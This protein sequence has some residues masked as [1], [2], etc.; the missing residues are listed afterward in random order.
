MGVK[1]G[2]AYMPG[3]KVGIKLNSGNECGR[4]GPVGLFSRVQP[5]GPDYR[6]T[7]AGVRADIDQGTNRCAGN[8]MMIYYR[9]E[10][11]GCPAHGSVKGRSVHHDGLCAGKFQRLVKR[12]VLD[13][14][15]VHHDGKG[16]A[17]Y[18][19]G[20]RHVCGIPGAKQKFAQGI[21]RTIAS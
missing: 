11:A 9:N 4:R 18:F 5:V 6:R 17:P 7:G 12:E 20:E 3:K 15:S 1:I 10:L 16:Y 13:G 14:E 8:R 19:S 21:G 2:L